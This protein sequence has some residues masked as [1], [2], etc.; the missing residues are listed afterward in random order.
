MRCC[1]CCCPLL[2]LHTLWWHTLTGTRLASTVVSE[3]N[4]AERNKHHTPHCSSP[5]SSSSSSASHSDAHIRLS[6]M[7]HAPRATFI[8]IGS[9]ILAHRTTG[10]SPLASD[11]KSCHQMPIASKGRRRRRC[12]GLSAV[13]HRHD[14]DPPPSPRRRLTFLLT[15][16]VARLPAVDDVSR[17]F[18]TFIG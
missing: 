9:L 10:Q 18:F 6:P 14:K 3:P 13:R 5:S 8:R 15:R 12:R 1:C 11:L 16:S 2:P 17:P 7:T 4:P